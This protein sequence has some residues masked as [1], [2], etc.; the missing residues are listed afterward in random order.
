M[1]SSLVGG[2]PL[3]VAVLRPAPAHGSVM[4]G[5]FPF[6]RKESTMMRTILAAAAAALAGGI[7]LAPAAA[8]APAEPPDPANPVDMVNVVPDAIAAAAA[9]ASSAALQNVTGGN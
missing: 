1:I 7:A 4:R 3:V 5:K 6:E 2:H 9:D 8:A